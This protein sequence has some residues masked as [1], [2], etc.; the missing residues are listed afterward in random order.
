[1]GA[2][3]FAEAEAGG[4]HRTAASERTSRPRPE[5]LHREGGP[6][7]AADQPDQAPRGLP[8]PGVL[9]EAEHAPLHGHDPAR[10]RVRGGSPSARGPA[11]RLSDRARGAAARV[12]CVPRNRGPARH[13]RTARL[14]LPREADTGP[15]E[16][17]ERAS[18][19]RHWCVRRAA[20]RRQDRRWH[21]PRGRARMQHAD[22]GPPAPASRSVAGAAVAVPRHRRR[23]SGRSERA[24]RPGTAGSTSQ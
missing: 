6:P 3:P 20:R 11:E 17:R 9:Q 14:P 23:R 15:A 7:V 22:L 1:M 8:E 21:I 4:D 18:R 24:K 5:A 2:P 10:D 12:P 19:A 13:R 16:G